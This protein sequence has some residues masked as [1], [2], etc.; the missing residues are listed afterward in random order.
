M[1]KK[2][3]HELA[4]EL[5]IESKEVMQRLASLGVPVKSALSAVDEADV[6]RLVAEINAE[7]ER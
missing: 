2:R 6:K 7:R 5:K 1:V 3:V 4:K